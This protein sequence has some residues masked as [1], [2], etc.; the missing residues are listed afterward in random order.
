MRK[1]KI[2]CT[3]G[4]AT[5]GEEVITSLC[6][7][8]MNVARMNFSH[9]THD[10]HKRRIDT[11]KKVRE[12]LALD[13]AIMLDTKGPEYRIGTFEKGKVTLCGGDSFTFTIREIVGNES[14]VSVSY[15]RLARELCAGDIILLANGLLSFKVTEIK[16]TDIICEVLNGG[17]LSDRKSMSFPNKVMKQE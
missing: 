8:G 13:V 5:D 3:I 16:D 17:E 12:A 14:I 9:N 1:T 15:K 4:P 7:A 11:V 2:I 6:R 10:D